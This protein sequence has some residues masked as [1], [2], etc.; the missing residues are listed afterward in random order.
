LIL[1]FVERN[2]AVW[3]AY[4][5]KR[6]F[7][8][9]YNCFQAVSGGNIT[10]KNIL[11]LCAQQRQFRVFQSVQDAANLWPKINEIVQ[12]IV[13]VVNK[14]YYRRFGSAPKVGTAEKT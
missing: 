3:V 5:G 12:R 10:I 1:E 8:E 9:C 13:F 11:I 4:Q 6:E 7:L 14:D 2:H